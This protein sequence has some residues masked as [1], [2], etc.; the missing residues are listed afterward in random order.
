MWFGTVRGRLG[1]IWNNWLFY[2]TG[3]LAYGRLKYSAAGAG[4]TESGNIVIPGIRGGASTFQVQLAK[5][6][7]GASMPPPMRSPH[8]GALTP[9]AGPDCGWI[10][11]GRLT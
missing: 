5:L 10:A 1:Y 7:K 6:N 4:I 9:P 11:A 8:I 3:G 2:G